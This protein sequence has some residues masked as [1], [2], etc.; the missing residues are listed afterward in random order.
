LN[1]DPL[2]E[3][4][5]AL[6]L[7]NGESLALPET[8]GLRNCLDRRAGNFSDF[9]ADWEV[10]GQVLAH[11]SSYE[12]RSP[13]PGFDRDFLEFLGRF[14]DESFRP[15]P[16][17]L[18]KGLT[19]TE[20][21]LFVARVE[22]LLTSAYDPHHFFHPVKYAALTWSELFAIRFLWWYAPDTLLAIAEA[23]AA[24]IPSEPQAP[25]VIRL[26]L[27]SQIVSE[28]ALSVQFNITEGQRG[29]LIRSNN[30]L[31]Q[32]MG[33]NA[34]EM[35]LEK[36]EG[37]AT[38][39]QLVADF[40]YPKQVRTLGWMVH[41]LARN[42]NKTEIYQGLVTALHE[43]LPATIPAEDLKRLVGSMRGHMRYLSWAEPWL[44]QD[45]VYPLL[46][47][48]RANTDDACEI[49]VHEVADLLN[50]ELDHM[51]GQFDRA[52]E[53]QTT[54][55]AAFLFAY[56]NPPQQQASLK[57]MQAILKRQRRI[58]QQPLASTSNW[59]KWNEALVVSMWILTFARWGQYYL[60]GRDM[61]DSDLE[62]LSRSA[63][64]LAMVRSMD[65]WRSHNSGK[66]GELA[67]FLDQVE[68]LLA[69]LGGR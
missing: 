23:Q 69:E 37:L 68:G 17:D 65:E 26:S 51:L 31:L 52:R 4:M 40:S 16:I 47:N 12:F 45:V 36:P 66:E 46:Q 59:T 19:T 30:G 24:G 10:L 28:I 58:I 62:E 27:L 22:T 64:E 25:D 13:E 14:L 67:L 43:A 33:L 38:A 8:E 63:S 41:H 35:L 29:R 55:I 2:K 5:A 56:S 57:S 7:L 15:A 18:S 49:W 21:K 54:N 48:Q 6:G 42:P 3:R 61:A 60:R 1:G 53:G 50:P 34:I 39:L 11:S 32:W 44:F 20:P 9:T